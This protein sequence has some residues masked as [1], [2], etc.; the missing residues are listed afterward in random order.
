MK[1]NK[2]DSFVNASHL[3]L[4]ALWDLERREKWRAERASI[5]GF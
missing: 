1:K 4:S 5:T 2:R 3:E